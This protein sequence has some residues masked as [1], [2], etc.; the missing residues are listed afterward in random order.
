MADLTLSD[1]VAIGIVAIAAIL[2]IV[3]WLFRHKLSTHKL[4][5][6][7]VTQAV[8]QMNSAAAE[9]GQRLILALGDRYNDAP[10]DLGGA[11]GLPLLAG[12][13]SRSAFTDQPLKVVSGDGSLMLLSQMAAQRIYNHAQTPALFSPDEIHLAATAGWPFMA[14]LLPEVGR[15][16]NFG[17]LMDGHFEG[18]SL[19]ALDLAD[20]KQMT[21]AASSDA[22]T[23]QGAIFLE[24]DSPIVGEDH[25]VP[26][27]DP[28]A[29]GGEGAILSALDVLRVAVCLALVVGAVLKLAGLLP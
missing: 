3:Y 16:G 2:S 19:L 10:G 27:F 21:I 29:K 5:R 6:P 18:E 24:T 15:R 17:L 28:A 23:G 1:L 22:I 8:E 12:C 25:F 14:G 13:T 20:R 9:K 4:R 11:A 26:F 7:D